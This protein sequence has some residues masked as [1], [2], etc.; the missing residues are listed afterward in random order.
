MQ[1]WQLH[2]PRFCPF[3]ST[4][5]A[6]CIPFAWVPNLRNKEGIGHH[7]LRLSTRQWFITKKTKIIIY[8]S[9]HQ[10]TV[11]YIIILSLKKQYIILSLPGYL[12]SMMGEDKCAKHG[13]KSLKVSHSSDSAYCSVFRGE[14]GL[15]AKLACKTLT[16]KTLTCKKARAVPEISLSF[17]A[18]FLQIHLCSK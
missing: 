6:S 18:H 1:H 5:H 9:S 10:H 17:V 14:I 13:A 2:L 16:C 8:H 3:S 15:A 11:S 7:S 12:P 4:I